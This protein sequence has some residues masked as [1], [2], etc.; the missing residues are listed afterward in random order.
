MDSVEPQ[1]VEASSQKHH[2]TEERYDADFVAKD[3]YTKLKQR[4]KALRNVR[5]TNNYKTQRHATGIQ[6]DTNALP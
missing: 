1:G 2:A 5:L 6:K 3:K 4:F